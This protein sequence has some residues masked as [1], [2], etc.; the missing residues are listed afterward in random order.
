M[1]QS[2]IFSLYPEYFP[3]YLNRGLF[4]K[5]MNEGIWDLEIINI[6]NYIA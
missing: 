3:G 2:R 5:A 1:F 6:L 4:G